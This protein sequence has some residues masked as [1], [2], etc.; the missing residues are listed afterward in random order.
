MIEKD[1]LLEGIHRRY[2]YDFREY[3]EESLRRRISM[4]ISK[5]GVKTISAFQDRILHD[6]K[7]FERFVGTLAVHVTSMF[8]DPEFYLA[9]RQRVVPQLRTYPFIRIWIAGCSSGEEVYSTAIVLKEC[10]IYDRCRIYATDISDSVLKRAK[11]GI[12]PLTSMREY[13]SNYLKAGGEKEFSSY[14]TASYDHA[15]FRRSL[16][17]NVTFG[18]H[19]LTSDASFN[20]FNVIFCRNVMIYFTRALQ[21]RVLKLFDESVCRLG[22]L[23]LGSKETLNYSATEGSYEE[24]VKGRRLY[25][26]TK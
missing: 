12:F 25:R 9:F 8:R 3:A 22:V 4:A 14:Y 13:T 17:E 23:G 2:G 21:E 26:K 7:F 1:L 19:N 6:A 24:L 16:I 5:E 18:Q 15:L 20:E 10:G 11:E